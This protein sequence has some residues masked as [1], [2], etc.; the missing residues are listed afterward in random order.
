MGG[1]RRESVSEGV[2]VEVL[3]DLD[4]GASKPSVCLDHMAL[5]P[6]VRRCVSI[7]DPDHTTRAATDGDGDIDV[8]S[9]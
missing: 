5:W 1:S 8:G 3:A 7:S 2:P 9:F 6:L 4:H